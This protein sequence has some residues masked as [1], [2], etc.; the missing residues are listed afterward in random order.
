MSEIDFRLYEVGDETAILDT[1]NRTFREVCGPDYVDRSL[2]HWKWEFEGNPE[3]NRILLGIAD[4]GRVACQYAGIPMRVHVRDGDRELSFFHAVDSMVHPDF[5]KGLRKR[6]LFLDVAERYFERFGGHE[7]QLGF[8]Y[9]VR[10]AWRIG[11]RYLGYRL[12]RVLDFLV[13]ELPV[14]QET[15]ALAAVPVQTLERFPAAVDAWFD[16]LRAEYAC[17]TRK[18]RRYLNWRYADCPS[19]AYTIL[20]AERGGAPAGWMVLRTD[21]GLV[22][23][24]ATIGDLHLDPSDGEAGRALLHAA[25]AHA[26]EAGC[27]KLLTVLNP[28][29]PLQDF[30]AASGFRP[31]PSSTWLERKLGSRDWSAGL[32]QEWLAENWSYTLGDSDLF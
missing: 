27:S 28:Q 32:S 18:D 29:L 7:D 4:D 5:R 2:E 20:W 8:G 11:E 19:C 10:P 25:E 3:G 21:G 24:A 16:G 22:P 26:I 23:G 15:E 13:R 12:I 1:F 14:R 9:P 17:V 30:F 6:P 31:H